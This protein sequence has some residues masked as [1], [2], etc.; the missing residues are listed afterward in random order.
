MKKILLIFTFFII[1]INYSFAKDLSGNAVDCYEK[2]IRALGTESGKY[3][4]G[5]K[6]NIHYYA[7]AKFL[8]Q[9]KVKL[10]Y[11]IVWDEKIHRQTGKVLSGKDIEILLLENT[12]TYDVG[13]DLIIIDVKSDVK[14]LYDPYGRW[15]FF[16]DRRGG[17]TLIS[18]K[19]LEI[20]HPFIRSEAGEPQIK[21]KLVDYNNT[22]LFN[23]YNEF[24][25]LLNYLL[26]L[27][28]DSKRKKN[29]L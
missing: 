17:E 20:E 14:S 23:K 12:F 15:K 2:K 24:N 16:V 3:P 10:A 9:T 8:T 21:C 6:V 25:K 7:T 4:A 22:S 26:E 29:I 13:E 11:A 27:E 28:E 19:T 18:R 5:Y 1:I